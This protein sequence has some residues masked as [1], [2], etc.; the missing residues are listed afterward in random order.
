MK[1][2]VVAIIRPGTSFGGNWKDFRK[3]DDILA[4]SVMDAVPD[5]RPRWLLEDGGD[6]LCWPE[7]W[8]LVW[9]LP[10]GLRL[11]VIV[12]PEHTT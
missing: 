8:K 1:P 2:A 5:R 4:R 12:H 9:S 10:Y 3:R 11:W 6:N 7:L